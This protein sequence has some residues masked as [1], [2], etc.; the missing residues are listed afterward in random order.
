[1]MIEINA[2]DYVWS[3]GIT[4]TS[5][6][7]TLALLIVGP[8]SM[9]EKGNARRLSLFL[10]LVTVGSAVWTALTIFGLPPIA[11]FFLFLCVVIV[12][13]YPFG[14]IRVGEEG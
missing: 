12:F 13:T 14:L 2:W 6:G 11:G 9:N 4:M 8:R 3:V 5:A 1:M 10:S 7:L